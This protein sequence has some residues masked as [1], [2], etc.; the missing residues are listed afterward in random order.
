[1]T[2]AP[3]AKTLRFHPAHTRGEERIFVPGTVAA[4][5][6]HAQRRFLEFFAATIRNRNTRLAYA[7]AITQFFGWCEASGAAL[8]RPCRTP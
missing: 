7:R 6:A 5:G 1:M 2:L 4:A 3:V 8:S